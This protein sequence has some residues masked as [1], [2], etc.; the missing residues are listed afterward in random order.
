MI[1]FIGQ[2][3]INLST[4]LKYIFSGQAKW[5]DII[6]QSATIGFDS[7]GISLMIVII[8][9]SVIALQVSNQFLLTGG[10]SYI[11]GFLSVALIREI[12]PGFAALAIGARAGTAITAEMANMKVTSQV[13][14]MNVLK[15]NPIGYYFAPRIL[16][17]SITC[18]FVVVLADC[19]RNYCI[20]CNWTSS[21]PLF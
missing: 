5:K 18:V 7:L 20:L 13:D 10:E 8:A 14:A 6:M 1:S 11:G 3:V 16:A 2:C 17:S 9:S 12:A 21:R 4:T 15:V 19:W